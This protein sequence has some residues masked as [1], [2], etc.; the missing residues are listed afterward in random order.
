MFQKPKTVLKTDSQESPFS[1]TLTIYQMWDDSRLYNM[2][3][4]LKGVLTWN[5]YWN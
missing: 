5:L 4:S 2:I 3:T 1:H